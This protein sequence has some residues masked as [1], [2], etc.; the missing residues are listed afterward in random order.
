MENR[1]DHEGG[2]KAQFP[3][4]KWNSELGWEVVEKEMDRF[5]MWFEDG[6]DV[7]MS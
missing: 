6:M 5:E 7:S 2:S 1:L 4:K 3:L